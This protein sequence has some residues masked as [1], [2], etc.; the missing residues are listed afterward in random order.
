MSVS[1]LWDYIENWG[2]HEDIKDMKEIADGDTDDDD[3]NNNN[4]NNNKKDKD[5]NKNKE[6]SNDKFRYFGVILVKLTNF[7]IFV[8]LA[9]LL[10]L[11]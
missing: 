7:V 5:N 9:I 8:K 3:D 4:N 10:I 6:N 11:W 2:F 1:Q